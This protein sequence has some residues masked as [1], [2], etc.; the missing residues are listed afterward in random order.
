[1]VNNYMDL[2][3]QHVVNTLSQSIIS[4]LKEASHLKPIT[5]ACDHTFLTVPPEKGLEGSLL[6]IS[7]ALK[8]Y[9]FARTK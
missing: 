9:N 2:M 5:F 8:L 6:E 1:M 3:L 4:L 7:I